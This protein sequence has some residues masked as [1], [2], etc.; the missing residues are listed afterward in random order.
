MPFLAVAQL[1]PGAMTGI[2]H[3]PS[4]GVPAGW[5][6]RREVQMNVGSAGLCPRAIHAPSLLVSAPALPPHLCFSLNKLYLACTA[7]LMGRSFHAFSSLQSRLV[8]FQK[9]TAKVWAAYWDHQVSRFVLCPTQA[10]WFWCIRINVAELELPSGA[11]GQIWDFQEWNA[12]G[13]GHCDP[14]EALFLKC[15]K[16]SGGLWGNSCPGR[17]S[18]HFSRRSE[19]N[20]SYQLGIYPFILSKSYF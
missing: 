11:C 8:E 20:N 10:L 4:P 3:L 19:A 12:T 2:S 13:N 15:S 16:S 6:S 18:L 17:N 14:L 5:G 9:A 1:G 7:R